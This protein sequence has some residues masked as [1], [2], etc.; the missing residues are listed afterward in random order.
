MLDSRITK[1]KKRKKKKMEKKGKN[2]SN[3]HFV[4]WNSRQGGKVYGLM[5]KLRKF[6]Y[7]LIRGRWNI[8]ADPKR[9]RFANFT[10]CG[11]LERRD[12]RGNS[13]FR[14]SDRIFHPCVSYGSNVDL[15]WIM[16]YVAI[17]YLGCWL[18][19]L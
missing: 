12:I 17:S 10:F 8:Q 9:T 3:S 5:Q 14:F 16:M 13:L 18:L 1:K 19:V 11:Q 6:V 7:R 4:V 2:P 15:W